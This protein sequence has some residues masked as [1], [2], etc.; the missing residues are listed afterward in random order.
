MRKSLKIRPLLSVVLLILCCIFTFTFACGAAASEQDADTPSVARP[1]SDGQLKVSGS[2]L[3]N[4]DNEPA[5]LHGVSTH[6]LSYYPEF[7]NGSLFRFVSDNWNVDLVRLPMYSEEYVKAPEYNL[8]ILRT[9]IEAAIAAD[10]YVIVD[11]HILEDNDPHIHMEEAKVFFSMISE[12]YAGVPNFLYEICNE[13]N[14]DV[15]WDDIYDYA[16]QIVPLIRKASPDAPIF[17]GTPDYDRDLTG[18]VSKPFPDPNVMYSFHFYA[19]SHHDEMM[20][21]LG[22]A[23]SAGLPVFVTE[24]GISEESG[25]GRIDYE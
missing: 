23:L 17:I 9:G 19:A 21:L 4:Q 8:N 13:P 25:N 24:C 7:V 22:S 15:T 20:Q 3:V 14:G 12:E 18:P 2:A 5:V 1:S 6:G 10:Q 11:W 16:E